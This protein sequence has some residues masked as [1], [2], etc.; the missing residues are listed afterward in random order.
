MDCIKSVIDVI[1]IIKPKRG[2]PA[3]PK[4][5]KAPKEPKTDYKT[6]T[7]TRKAIYKYKDDLKLKDK[8]AFNAKNKEAVLKCRMKRQNQLHEAIDN[9]NNQ[10]DP[11]NKLIELIN[12]IND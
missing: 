3:K 2:R 4:A 10:S 9:I 5:P 6:P 8:E 11:V 12:N 7:Y 1:T